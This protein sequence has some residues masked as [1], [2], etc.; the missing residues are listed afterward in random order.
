MEK[1]RRQK[2]LNPGPLAL[3][4]EQAAIGR[5]LGLDWLAIRGLEATNRNAQIK[6]AEHISSHH[7]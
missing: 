6:T 5:K 2:E 7:F 3:K 1:F 4:N